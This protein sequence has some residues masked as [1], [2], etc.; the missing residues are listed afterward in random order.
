MSKDPWTAFWRVVAGPTARRFAMFFVGLS[1]IIKLGTTPALPALCEAVFTVT[2]PCKGLSPP[3]RFLPTTL[4]VATWF[5]ILTCKCG[6]HLHIDHASL[7]LCYIYQFRHPPSTPTS[8]GSVHLSGRPCACV[9]G[10]EL[11]KTGARLLRCP[12]PSSVFRPQTRTPTRT[13]PK[14]LRR[15]AVLMLSWLLRDL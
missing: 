15:H 3:V 10:A 9:R 1:R 2:P 11:I 4:A 5:C 13:R 14:T 6:H 8:C 12:I 7:S